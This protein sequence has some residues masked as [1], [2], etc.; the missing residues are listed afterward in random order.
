MII[1]F[2]P[3]LLRAFVAVVD[4][5]SFTRAA[6]RLNLTQSAISH[7][8]RR[9]E[10]QVG[11]PLLHRTTRSL[12]LTEDGEDFLRSSEQIIE[13]LDS[14]TRRF[15]PSP[16]SGIVRF[17]V[18]ENFMGDRLP[19][20][21]CQFARSFPAARLDVHV[22][23]YI[24]LRVMVENDDLDLAVV[25]AG[26]ED[27]DKATILR[28]TQLVWVASDTFTIASGA[29]L[30]LALSPIPCFHRQAGV[31][32]L[33]HTSIQWHVVFT[34]PSQ[35]G[36]HAAVLSGLAITVLPES[37]VRPGMKVI[38]GQYG[39][40]SL[41]Q[42][43]FTLIWSGGSKTAAAREFGKLISDMP[44]PPKAAPAPKSARRLA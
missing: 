1:D 39:L 9:L 44:E 16:V 10:E 19:T 20:L 22:G 26:E 4:T 7:Q 40:P 11:R 32:A 24:D 43:A 29:S 23:P 41:P 37:D 25:L 8:I 38:D 30:P 28:W 31:A 15:K 5:G 27:S 18:P 42:A 3:A 6:Q 36:L 12:T 2:D 21:L 17:G 35:H 34:S 14:L 33:D 13:M